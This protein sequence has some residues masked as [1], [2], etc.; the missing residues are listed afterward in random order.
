MFFPTLGNLKMYKIDDTLITQLDAWLGT[1]RKAVVDFLN[2][3]QF[4]I[5]SQIDEQY[6]IYLFVMCTKPKIEVLKVKYI[7]ECPVCDKIQQVYFNPLEIPDKFSCLECGSLVKVHED[8]INIWFELIKKPQ[9]VPMSP[10]II[11]ATKEVY[12]LG[13]QLAFVQV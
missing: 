11:E 12:S 5:D 4:S 2:P 7:L 10:E 8:Y 3:L 1:R 9:D 13:K 6:A